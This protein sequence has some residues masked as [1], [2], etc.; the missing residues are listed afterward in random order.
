MKYKDIYIG[1]VKELKH[2]ITIKDIEKFVD[3]TGDDNRLHVDKEFASKTSFRQP[4]VHGMLGASFISTI[5]GTKLPGDGALWFSQSLDFL[6]PVRINDTI[7][8]RAEVIKMEKREQIIHL[9]TEIYNQKKQLVVRGTSK[10][11]IVEQLA[12]STN[13]KPDSDKKRK[14]ALIIGS[15][16]G[17]GEKVTLALAKEGYEIALHYYSNN[18]KANQLNADLKSRGIFSRTYSC[19]II[20]QKQVDELC[21]EVINDFGYLDVLV[22]CSTPRIVPITF[23]KLTW[24]DMEEHLFQQIKGSFNLCKKLALIFKEQGYGKII[25]LNSQFLDT[26][27]NNWLHYITGK[28]AL[29]GFT[30]ALATELAPFGIQVNS[31]SPGLTDTDIVADMPEKLKLLTIAKTP[32]RRVAKP[33]EVANLVA[34]L[35]S[36]KANF[37]SGETFRLNGGQFML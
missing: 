29:Y 4:V 11:K 2:T 32:L 35:T 36:D 20:D 6:L 9:L 26:P 18:E 24:Q 25:S 30:K 14:I 16:G 37:F 27:V 17:I 33:E 34:F 8:V 7:T 21:S 23:E 22:N 10:V 31:I 1:L 13:Q 12:E 19:D 3:L 5:I 28:G 15:T